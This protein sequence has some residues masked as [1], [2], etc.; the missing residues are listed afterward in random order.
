MTGRKLLFSLILLLISPWLMRFSG[1]FGIGLFVGLILTIL[2]S[3]DYTAEIHRRGVHTAGQNIV[4]WL[5]R[6][7]QLLFGL[8]AV[9]IGLVLA[10]WV[11]YNMLIERLPEYSSGPLGWFIIPALLLFGLNKLRL[12]FASPATPTT[13]TPRN[14][15]MQ[16]IL[17]DHPVFAPYRDSLLASARPCAA[18]T[19]RP[20]ETLTDT[21]TP[22]QSKLGGLPYLPHEADYPH[23][24]QGR[25]LYLLAQINCAEVPPLP[26]F[27][28]R[29]M[30]QFFIS[31]YATLVHLWGLDYHHPDRQDYFRVLYYPEVHTDPAAVQ[32]D[33]AFL[34]PLP[35][36]PAAMTWTQKLLGLF[37]KPALHLP[38]QYPCAMHF[39]AG[40]QLVPLDDAALHLSGA[41]VP[42]VDAGNWFDVLDD[43]FTEA[44]FDAIP[45]EGHRLGG[46]AH[47]VQEDLRI[48]ENSPY[49][50]YVLLLQLD[51]D[52]ANGMMWGDLGVCHFY[53]HPD[54]LRRRDFSRVLYNWEC[55]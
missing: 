49:R 42:D 46:Y 48:V 6:V 20:C 34:P 47:H 8:L 27:P 41:G 17:P 3:F 40:E 5:L 35:T 55:Y 28:H 23:D 2:Y 31:P 39:T 10:I 1:W 43:D 19:L 16:H 13:S 15:A 52:E 12:L 22:W 26:D 4:Y 9:G 29:G 30:L 54:D 21:L 53:I 25:P 36:P 33:F 50:D 32:Q 24:S 18:I 37:K 38:F 14:A 45:H 11:F 7:P 44:Y 51:S